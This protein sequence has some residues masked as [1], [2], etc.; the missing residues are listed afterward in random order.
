MMVLEC[1][2]LPFDFFLVDFVSCVV[3]HIITFSWKYSKLSVI[4]WLQAGF[5]LADRSTSPP[6]SLIL[7][8]KHKKSSSHP[9]FRIRIPNDPN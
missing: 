3:G 6:S 5:H 2:T 7:N 9:V 8:S 4:T 1:V